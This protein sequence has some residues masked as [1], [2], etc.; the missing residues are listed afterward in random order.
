MWE[1]ALPAGNF[2]LIFEVE[3]L[4]DESTITIELEDAGGESPSLQKQSFQVK[5]GIQRIEYNFTKPFAPYQSRFVVSG[6]KGSCQML[7]F[8][9]F[10][11]Y[12]KLSDDFDIWRTSGIQPEWIARFEK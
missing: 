8:K 4:V 3:G 5:K 10:P 1:V 7:T 2:K 12:Q 11:N 6:L 9:L